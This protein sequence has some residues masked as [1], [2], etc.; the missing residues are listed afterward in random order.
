MKAIAAKIKRYFIRTDHALWVMCVM[1]SAIGA[2]LLYGCLVSGYA[3]SLGVSR[4]MFFIQIGAALAGIFAA[5][6]ISLIDY[7]FLL[8][9]WM[10]HIPLAYFLVALTFFFGFGH[11]ERPDDRRWLMLPFLNMQF[12]PSELLKISFIM[13]FALHIHKLSD[14]IGRLIPVISLALHICVPVVLIHLQGDDGTALLIG[15]TGIAMMFLSGVK[16]RYFLALASGLSVGVPLA[17]YYVLSPFQKERIT[18]LFNQ[19]TAD[20]LGIYYQQYYAKMAIAMGGTT[21]IGL[22]DAA[23]TYIPIMHNDFIF[24]FLAES[25]GFMGALGVLSLMVALCLKILYNGIRADDSRGAAICCGV[26]A[27]LLFQAFIN[28][29]MCLSLLPVIG[30]TFPFLSQGGSSVLTAYIGIGLVMSVYMWKKEEM[31]FD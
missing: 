16:W 7:R 10:V 31:F 27:M 14:S 8:K 28:V 23:H 15:L 1:M 26:F 11:I 22:F 6:I 13:S 25:F 5:F 2:V 12:Q 9:T 21:G 19:D 30:N 20:V 17:W 24:A 4:R 3:A 29:G 18:V